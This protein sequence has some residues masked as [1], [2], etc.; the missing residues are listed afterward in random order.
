[1]VTHHLLDIL[2]EIDR[3][4]LLCNGCVFADGAKSE[5]LTSERLTELFGLPVKL[6]RRDGYYQL[7]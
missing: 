1:M 5:V 4:I 2:P 3:V 6:A 7:W